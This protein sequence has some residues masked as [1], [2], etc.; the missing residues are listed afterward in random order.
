MERHPHP[1]DRRRHEVALTDSGR[2]T[3]AEAGDP[4]V[5][6]QMSIRGLTSEQVSQLRAIL[7]VM[8]AQEPRDPS[9]GTHRAAPPSAQELADDLSQEECS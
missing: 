4:R 3:L 8:L 1:G 2:R 6:E 7:G 5:A 9:P